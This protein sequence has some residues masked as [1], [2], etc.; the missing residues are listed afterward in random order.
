MTRR[1]R[2][3]AFRISRNQVGIIA[4]LIPFLGVQTERPKLQELLKKT[5]PSVKTVREMK[6]VLA[7]CCSGD[8]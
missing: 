5:R 6:G 8:T 3:P 4:P 2:K 7:F 1:H